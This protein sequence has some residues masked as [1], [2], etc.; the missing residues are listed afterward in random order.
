[1][2][3][4]YE[5]SRRGAGWVWAIVGII[6]AALVIWWVGAALTD[7]T[8]DSYTAQGEQVSEGYNTN[9]IAENEPSPELGEEAITDPA[10]DSDELA[11]AD[12]PA[13]FDEAESTGDDTSLANL[14][15]WTEQDHP[16][17]DAAALDDGTARLSEAAGEVAT[18]FGAAAL[19]EGSQVGGGPPDES[20]QALVSERTRLEASVEELKNSQS[21]EYPG[22]F[23]QV[24]K[25]FV[26][27]VDGIQNQADTEE[28]SEPLE[29]LHGALDEL[30]PTQ[31]LDEQESAIKSFFD[32]GAQVLNAFAESTAEQPE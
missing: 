27:L 25:D 3:E 16:S 30:S 9:E 14:N 29:Q 13:G 18:L 5:E 10:Q 4:R 1:M 20:A 32:N 15:A 11:Q 23:Y 31:D 22:V 26:A 7:N 8:D 17:L 2:V 21:A 19:D 28:A 6:V 24:A 12:L